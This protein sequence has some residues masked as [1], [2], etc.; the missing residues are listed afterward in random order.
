LGAGLPTIKISRSAVAGLP[1]PAKPTTYYDAD[2]PGFGLKLLPSGA[3][4]WIVEYRPGI[5]GRGT[6]KR[7]V[8]LGRPPLVTPEKARQLAKD[9][10]ATARVG[11]DPAS[12]RAED[13][14]SIT[15]SELAYAFMAEHVEPRRKQSTA[16]DY[17]LVFEK[18]V[19]PALGSIKAAKLTRR[20]R[21]VAFSSPQ[22]AVSSQQ[23]GCGPCLCIFVCR[24]AGIGA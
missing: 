20:R 18:I 1:T 2:L 13:R 17:K 8:V 10:L 21:E 23:S 16:G 6:A 24:E 3:R 11:A 12:K 5:S 19:K 22:H 7:R 14:A 15:V 9:I 4:S